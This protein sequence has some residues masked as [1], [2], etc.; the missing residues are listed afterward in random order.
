MVSS[1]R[2]GQ[3][4]RLDEFRYVARGP[5]DGS[6]SFARTSSSVTVS[7][8]RCR[9]GPDDPLCLTDVSLQ[10]DQGEFIAIVGPVG[11]GKSSLLLA[12][13]GEL[14]ALAGQIALQGRLAYTAQ[15]PWGF[16]CVVY[17]HSI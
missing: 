5:A 6:T 16:R 2:I 15:V 13:L 7:G 9:W 12:L 1:V 4:L 14:P 8:V 17:V 11:C 10:A 3:F